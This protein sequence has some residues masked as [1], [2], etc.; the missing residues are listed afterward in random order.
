M[1]AEGKALLASDLEQA[2]ERFDESLRYNSAAIGTLLN[3][4]LC[5]EKLGRVASALAKFTE[6]RSRAAEQGLPQHVRAAEEHIAALTPSVPHL[7][8]KLTEAI[9]G[10]QILI[11]DRVVSPGTLDIAV[12]PG[13]RVIVVTAPNRLP[14]RSKLVVNRFE[15]REVV[16]PPL[17]ASLVVRSSQRRIS[18]ISTAAGGVAVVTGIGLGLYARSLYLSAFGHPHVPGDGLCNDMNICESTGQARTERAR[19]LGNVGTVVGLFGVATAAVGAYL[20]YRSPTSTRQ[21]A[22]GRLTV[23]PSICRDGIVVSAIG[24]F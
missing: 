8:I 14:F 23:A 9:P 19:T 18:Q 11:D 7:V 5:D 6:A 3:V 17:E 2:C 22:D 13:E 10:I 12:D 24:R 15:H 20:W 1:F 16:V 21:S 4:A